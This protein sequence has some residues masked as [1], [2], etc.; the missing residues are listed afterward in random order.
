[1]VR[2]SDRGGDRKSKGRGTGLVRARAER[3]PAIVDKGSHHELREGDTTLIVGRAYRT[4]FG[5]IAAGEIY[6]VE[7]L[8]AREQ[9]PWLGEADKVAWRD[10]AT[11]YECIMLRATY[12]GYLSGYVGVPRSHPLWGYEHAAVPPELG[13]EVHGGLTY[14]R[15]CEEGPAP[16]RRLLRREAQRICHIPYDPA[17]Y[18]PILHA[19]D[20]RV[21]DPHAWWFGFD[22]NHAYDI[23][24]GES[25]ASGFLKAEIG[26]EYR[27]DAY[28]CNEVLNLAAQLRAIAEGV[29]MPE[30]RGPPLP[31]LG[32]DPRKGG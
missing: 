7:G 4:R 19:T 6:Y 16:P 22:C 24:P 27:D 13:I 20:H 3:A 25:G 17:N 18:G 12:G 9:G 15:I 14:G 1:M 29:P 11:G 10:P 30:R 28:V 23:V 26:G 2:R 21:E 5:E 32:L 8:K 31:P